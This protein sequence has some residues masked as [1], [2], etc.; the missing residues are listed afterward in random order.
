VCCLGSL[1][2]ISYMRLPFKAHYI[3]LTQSTLLSIRQGLEG[4]LN[5]LNQN[6]ICRF[7]LRLVHLRLEELRLLDLLD[8]MSKG[9]LD[10]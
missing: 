9:G 3:T 7:D 10:V 1:A 2:M 8:D 6:I 5:L 4:I